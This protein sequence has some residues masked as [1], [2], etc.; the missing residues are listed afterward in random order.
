MLAL[1]RSARSDLF[2]EGVVTDSGT[3]SYC[4]VKFT[5]GRAK[6]HTIKVCACL[7]VLVFVPVRVV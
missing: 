7:C 5:E 4:K 3:T 1:H 2:F 6:G